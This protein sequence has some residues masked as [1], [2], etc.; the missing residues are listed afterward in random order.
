MQLTRRKGGKST[1]RHPSL[2]R[3][4]DEAPQTLRRLLW[5]GIALFLV[6]AIYTI[7]FKFP[8][9][10]KPRTPFLSSNLLLPDNEQEISTGRLPAEGDL[11]RSHVEQM[12]ACMPTVPRKNVEY[13]SNAVKSWRL[14]TNTSD[15]LRRLVVLDMNVPST[16]WKDKRPEWL[17]RVFEN[18][19]VPVPSWL[20]MLQREGAPQAAR[21]STLGDSPSRIAWRSKE[22]QDYAQTLTRCA[23]LAKGRYVLIVQDDVLF[24]NA[25][26]NV[27]QW[28]DNAFVQREYTDSRGRTSV[29]RVCSLSLFDVASEENHGKDL[30]TLDSSNMVARIWRTEDVERVA[31]YIFRRFDEAPVD[32]LIDDLCKLRRRVTLVK[33]PNAVRHRGAVSSFSENI[34]EGLLT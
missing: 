20:V 24:T 9:K 8:Q 13:V 32:W 25:L 29:R 6:I 21:K 34:R 2:P 33:E 19:D 15:T 11:S 17:G 22:A 28:A 27:V 1:L 18:D 31:N 23:E 5:W 12:L 26:A 7:Y 16:K 30:H 4:H 10:R 14:A 3:K